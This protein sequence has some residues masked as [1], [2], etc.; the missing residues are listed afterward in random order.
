MSA[1]VDIGSSHETAVF[2]LGNSSRGLMVGL[3]SG[4]EI[5]WFGHAHHVRFHSAALRSTRNDGPAALG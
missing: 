1:R 3:L 2:P 5:A 4:A